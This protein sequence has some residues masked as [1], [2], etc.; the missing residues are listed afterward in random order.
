MRDI[1]EFTWIGK[2]IFPVVSTIFTPSYDLSAFERGTRQL[3]SLDGL[4]AWPR[5]LPSFCGS[6]I[7]RHMDA[8][9]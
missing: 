8:L 2:K 7:C 4:L 5:A 6:V 3:A 9:F 1:C